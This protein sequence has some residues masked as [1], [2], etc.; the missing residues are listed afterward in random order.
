MLSS[1]LKLEGKEYTRI[2]PALFAYLFNRIDM[3]QFI[4]YV[5]DRAEG[6]RIKDIARMNGYILKHCKLYAYAAHY[7][8]AHGRSSPRPRDYGVAPKDAALLRKLNLAHVGTKFKC[9][10]LDEF[11]ATLEQVL[12]SRDVRNY[13]GKFITKKMTFL[14]QSYGDKRED[15]ES[16][17][18]EAATL[19]I[20]KTYPRYKS[21]LHF[22]NI[23]KRQI[24]NTGQ[25]HIT[26]ST[27]KSRQKLIVDDNG[28]HSSVH[29]PLDAVLHLEAPP[30][31]GQE[32]VERLQALAAIEDSL[33][34]RTKEFLLCAAGQYHEGFS[35]FLKARNDDVSM[36]LDYNKYMTKL[37]TYF[38]VSTPALERLFRNLRN[39][40]YRCH[41][42][43]IGAAAN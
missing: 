22:V 18:K 39:K 20:Y 13:I 42:D 12:D 4:D 16:L 3:E 35:A 19:A 33:P 5:G 34:E 14:M 41:H 10:T 11:D 38:N 9:F 43:R 25:T 32:I 8:R 40:I 29:M 1:I 24:H 2:V 15:L 31:Y 23:A 6:T 21:Y 28:E 36:S 7:E 27:S 30:V 26:S 17:L 37:Q